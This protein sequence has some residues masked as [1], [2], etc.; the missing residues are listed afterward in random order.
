M[1]IKPHHI[2]AATA[3]S[4]LA[5]TT[6]LSPV[7]AQTPEAATVEIDSFIGRVTITNGD[8]VSIRG[9][10]EGTLSRNGSSLVIDGKDKV[11]VT[12]CRQR[13]SRVELSFGDWSWRGRS[14]GYK[15][16]DEYPHLKITVPEDTRLIIKDSVIYGDVETIDSAEINMP[17]C[18][19]LVIGDVTGELD[20]NIAGSADLTAQDVGEASIKITGSGDVTVD[21][22][23]SLSLNITGSGDFEAENIAGDVIISVQ[24]SGD[25][26]LD[27]LV[28]SLTYD[29][30]G[31]G[32]LNIDKIT[33]G[34][35]LMTLQGSG[36]VE[37]DSGKVEDINITV[38]GSGDVSYGGSAVD[39]D[40]TA[41]GS[42]N[43]YVKKASGDVQVSISSS[44][45]VYVNGNHY[46]R[47]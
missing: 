11:E 35:V 36:D 46:E 33:Q 21:D 42:S 20:V 22:V 2:L 4:T 5:L 12:S 15:N 32:D 13:N 34:D 47:N 25:V 8:E 14:G 31:S 45:D 24:G 16:I 40:I 10:A 1:L 26:E 43:V 3:L 28:G 17:H 18:S 30:Q 41:H 38:R 39:A 9:E 7:L 27:K 23:G 19:D 37:I 29:S 6:S 44:A